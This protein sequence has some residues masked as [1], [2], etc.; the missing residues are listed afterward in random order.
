[1][2]GSELG[3]RL[4]LGLGLGLDISFNWIDV[5]A[6][7]GKMAGVCML[8]ELERHVLRSFSRSEKVYSPVAIA[9]KLRRE[10]NIDAS[11]N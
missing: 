7:A 1:M 6:S 2:L 5:V 3:L 10:Y 8:C 11:I 4:G 9:Q